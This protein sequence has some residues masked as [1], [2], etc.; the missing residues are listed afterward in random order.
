MRTNF[1][2]SFFI[3]LFLL[4]L[5]PIVSPAQATAVDVAYGPDS[6]E[7][8]DYYRAVIPNRPIIILIHAG[9]WSVGD[10]NQI[11]WEDA[12]QMF[13]DSGY[14]VINVNYILASEIR[15]EGFPRQPMDIACVISWAKQ[16]A[17]LINGDT[18]N[19]V[20]FG[21]SAGAHLAS[22]AGLWQSDSLLHHCRTS[23]SLN[24]KGVVSLSGIYNFDIC[25]LGSRI[26][27]FKMLIDSANTYANAQ[28][29]NHIDNSTN[30]KFLIMHGTDDMV[31]GFRQPKPFYD[32]LIA[33][34]YCA[35]LVI[36]T[37]R[38]H[39]LMDN[40]LHDTLVFNKVFQFVD[41][42]TKDLLCPSDTS[43]ASI[44]DISTSSYYVYPNPSSGIINIS[45]STMIPISISLVNLLGEKLIDKYFQGNIVL[46]IS[47][48]PNGFYYLSLKD[49]QHER[50][51]KMLLN[52]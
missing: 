21:F 30:T 27:I 44:E 40:P 3:I 31:A 11:D 42:L 7:T 18:S 19:I 36:L 22:L 17:S 39:D 6:L 14:A 28:P 43:K 50:Q 37:G 25:P 45:S 29:K 48:Y 9:S 47:A 32:S 52:H 51:Q 8:L 10:K 41:S 12:S 13:S 26:S 33:K 34:G 16:N 1:I 38:G 23:S 4:L 20:L 15:Y 24:V 5:Q 49:G 35:Q 2:S 46:D